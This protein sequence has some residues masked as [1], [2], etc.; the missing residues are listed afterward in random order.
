M[1]Y[2]LAYLADTWVNWCP[3]LGT[4]LANDEVVNGVSESGG[5]PVE[6]KLM[7]QWSLRITA[8]AQRL[9][10]GLDKIDWFESLKEMQR[11]WIGRSEGGAVFLQ[12]KRSS[13]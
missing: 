9:L 8:Y 6:R 13:R 10:D 1:N 4:V 3:A 12:N 7:K 2:R 11:Y 5:H